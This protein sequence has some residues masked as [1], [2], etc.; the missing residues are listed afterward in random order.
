[1]LVSAAETQ[2]LKLSKGQIIYTGMHA[3]DTF[4]C[5]IVENDDLPVFGE[6]DIQLDTITLLCCAPKGG[7]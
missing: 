2:F 3:A 5:V 1:M 6:L 7:K 4:Q